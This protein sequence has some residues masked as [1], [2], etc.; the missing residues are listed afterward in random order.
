MYECFA[1]WKLFHI[2]EKE[3]YFLYCVMYSLQLGLLSGLLSVL[4]GYFSLYIHN[5]V[6]VLALPIIIY[7]ILI[8][9]SGNTIYTVFIFRA[10]NRP[11][12]KDWESFSLILLISIIPTILLGCFDI[13]EDSKR[14][15]KNMF[16][17]MKYIFE[18]I[19]L[20]KIKKYKR[21]SHFA[22]YYRRNDM[23]LQSSSA[24][25]DLLDQISGNMVRISFYDFKFVFL[26]LFWFG[27][28]YIN[29]RYSIYAAQ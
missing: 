16:K 8:E 23:E 2:T 21:L 3:H 20:L 5:R 10:Y 17:I 25:I 28:I 19:L 12:N 9:C 15:Y 24:R 1:E 6:T 7:Q 29:F 22:I 18:K 13:Q 14:G 26:I 4:A 27:I 11:M